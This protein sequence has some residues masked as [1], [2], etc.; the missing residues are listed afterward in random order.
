METDEGIEFVSRFEAYYDCDASHIT[1]L[2]FSTDANI[3]P[4]WECYCGKVAI[5]RDAE[6]NW[7]KKEKQQRTHWD[8]LT[9]RRNQEDLK[10]VFEKQVSIIK[11]GRVYRD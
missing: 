11:S 5:L 4:C 3:P 8:M 2:P 1:I 7:K 10:K 9:E 6:N